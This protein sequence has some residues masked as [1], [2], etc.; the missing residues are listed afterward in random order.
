MATVLVVDDDAT[1]RDVLYDLFSEE[2][3]CHT[4]ESA[5]RALE[6]LEAGRYDVAILDV[7]LPRMS[8]LELL[9]HIHQRWPEMPVLI[10]TGIDYQQYAENL[11]RMGAFDYIEKPFR[12]Q[13]AQGKLAG[14][15]LYHERW[16]ETVKYSAERALK[17]GKHLMQERRTAVRHRAQRAARLLFKTP[18]AVKPGESAPS[19]PSLF[20]HTH[21]ISE[22][23]LAV[24]V[25][26]VRSSDPN[27]YGAKG[28][29]QV[30]LSLSTGMV[31][32]QATPVR[33]EWVEENAPA[34]GFLVGVRIEGMSDEDRKRFDGFLG[35]IP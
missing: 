24:L 22:T 23:G 34:R 25:P 3:R 7:S 15:V 16:L 30:T 26:C 9:G 1:I 13:D 6:L 19:L 21:D 2:H 4:A 32:M 31:E 18:P 35:A 29:L 20:G 14:A 27:F 11:L 5:E 17:H 12:L 10:V 28:S 33:Y 8:G